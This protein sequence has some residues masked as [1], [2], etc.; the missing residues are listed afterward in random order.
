MWIKAQQ[1]A[2]VYCRNDSAEKCT[3]VRIV[4]AAFVAVPVSRRCKFADK[5]LQG[6]F[7]ADRRLQGRPIQTVRI[8]LSRLYNSK[9]KILTPVD[10]GRFR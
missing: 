6:R 10:I 2:L 8:G 7:L 9:C 3:G 1:V 4:N 5:L